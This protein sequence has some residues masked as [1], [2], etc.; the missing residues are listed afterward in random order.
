MNPPM[1]PHDRRGATILQAHDLVLSFGENP[2]PSRSEPLVER[3][4]I[5][6]VMGP[7]GSGKSTLLHCLA[8]SSFRTPVRSNSM[9]NDWIPCEK[10]S[11]RDC[12]VIASASC[13]SSPAGP[14][15]TAE[16]NVACL[17]CLVAAPW[18]ASVK[19]AAGFERLDLVGLERQRAGEMSGGSPNG[20]L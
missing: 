9:V 18:R 3:G 20:W 6:A 12:D 10:G 19:R 13:S 2:S 4:E 16:E 11:A 5:V 1:G 15:L 7:S 14:E 17:C 8:G